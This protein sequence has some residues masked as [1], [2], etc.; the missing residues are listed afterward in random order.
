MELGGNWKLR[1]RKGKIRN[2]KIETEKEGDTHVNYYYPSLG[3][4]IK[5][6]VRPAPYSGR[7]RFKHKQEAGETFHP[8]EAMQW[9]WKSS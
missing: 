9:A 1:G 4:E 6:D 7:W 3:L 8:W 5:P 2:G